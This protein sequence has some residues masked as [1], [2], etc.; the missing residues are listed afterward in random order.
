MHNMQQHQTPALFTTVNNN[1][2]NDNKPVEHMNNTLIICR[3]PRELN[4]EAKLLEHFKQFGKILNIKCNYEGNSDMAIV[5]FSLLAE[6]Q[7]AYKCPQPLFNNRFIRLFWFSQKSKIRPRQQPQQQ[8]QVNFSAAQ[9]S[10]AMNIMTPSNAHAQSNMN[11]EDD[12]TNTNSANNYD[13][14][15]GSVARK[16]HVKDRLEFKALSQAVD[17]PMAIKTHTELVQN[18]KEN[19]LDTKVSR[20]RRP[21]PR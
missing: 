1:N 2:N 16:K 8:Q 3:I 17:T 5:Q 12:T 4:T 10:N 6:A 7:S 11:T 15:D 14:Y 13:D 21:W 20:Q 9:S 19:K 18:N